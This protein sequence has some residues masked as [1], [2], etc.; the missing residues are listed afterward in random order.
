MGWLFDEQIVNA[1]FLELIGLT[2]VVAVIGWFAHSRLADG[3][4][5]NGRI[6]WIV[7]ALAGPLNYGFWTLFNIIE[8]HWGLD[9][10]KPLLINAA[11]FVAIGM[12][13]GLVL[14]LL[15]RPPTP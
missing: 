2:P 15:L 13:A 3:C 12:V 10:V 11:I 14:R 6:G 8:N 1:V 4:G 7:V 9:R 5:R